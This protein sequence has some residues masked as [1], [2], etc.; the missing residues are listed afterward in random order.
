[1]MMNTQQRIAVLIPCYNEEAAISA[2]VHDF[3]AAL[4]EATIFVFDNNSRDRTVE[5][6]RDAGAVV[7]R[8]PLQG[9]G[10]VVRR[11]FADVDAD[12]YVLV[13]GDATYDAESIH[14]L[15]DKLL[16]EHLDMVVGCRQVTA[17]VS[18]AAYRHG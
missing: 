1:M 14:N 10:N 17:E 5:V 15:V 2:V 12:A 6:A 4:P 7:C 13:D 16:D 18:D 8:V 3:R 9:K 11:M